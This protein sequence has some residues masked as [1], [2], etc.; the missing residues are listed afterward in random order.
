MTTASPEQTKALQRNLEKPKAVKQAE[1]SK[2]A[3]RFRQSFGTPTGANPFTGAPTYKPLGAMTDLPKG[4]GGKSPSP[5]Q[6][7]NVRVGNLLDIQK[8]TVKDITPSR[9]TSSSTK[10]LPPARSNTSVKP[11][12]VKT[13]TRVKQ[14]LNRRPAPE[15]SFKV[16]GTTKQTKAPQLPS[17]GN[18][19]APKPTA[20]KPVRTNIPGQSLKFGKTRSGSFTY[21]PGT[22]TSTTPPR[23]APPTPVADPTRR[24]ASNAAGPSSRIDSGPKPPATQQRPARQPIPPNLGQG[25][26]S[27]RQG[28]SASY[29]PPTTAAASKPFKARSSSGAGSGAFYGVFNALDAAEREKARGQSAQRQRDSAIASGTGSTLGSITA[30]KALS[31]LLGPRGRFVSDIAGPLI[32]SGVGSA[33]AGYMMGASKSDK[34]WMARQNRLNQTGVS[35]QSATSKRGNRAVIRDTSGK[36][37]VGYLAYKDG[38]PVYKTANDPSSLAYT[39]S[40]PLE[41]VGRRTADAGIPIVSDYLKGFYNRPMIE[42]E[43]QMLPLKDLER[44]TNKYKY[45]IETRDALQSF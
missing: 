1:V 8:V 9:G 12:P 14:S 11:T 2:R 31:R 7:G 22:T 27:P 3:A 18:T 32:G 24:R 13:M 26:T 43:R 42:P 45:R 21:K 38:K 40:N 6:Y 39:S 37:R 25:S 23:T 19:T 28:A 36:E 44:V 30:T 33:A 16:S 29:K 17:V 10:A 34:E 5:R 41:R 20:V 15:P 35:A 4:R